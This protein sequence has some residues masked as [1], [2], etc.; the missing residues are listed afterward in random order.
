MMKK[1]SVPKNSTSCISELHRGGRDHRHHAFDD[2][3]IADV[4]AACRSGRSPARTA[5]RR[6]AASGRSSSCSFSLIALPSSGARPISSV[7]GCASVIDGDIHG[8]DQQQ[9]DHDRHHPGGNAAAWWCSGSPGRTSCRPRW[10]PGPAPPAC[11]RRTG[12][13]RTPAPPSGWW[14]PARPRARN[15]RRPQAAWDRAPPA[16]ALFEPRARPALCGWRS[17]RLVCGFGRRSRAKRRHRPRS[18]GRPRTRRRDTSAATGC[19]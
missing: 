19:R 7:I 12:R 10:R 8:A 9:Q 2:A 14:R 6:S 11:R 15:S 4:D 17:C 3:R 5:V 1:N 18:R 16:P 13:R